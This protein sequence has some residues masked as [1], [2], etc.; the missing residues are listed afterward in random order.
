ML[1]LHRLMAPLH[2]V[3]L[4]IAA[5]MASMLFQQVLKTNPNLFDRLGEYSQSRFGFVPTDLPFAFSIRPS[6]RDIQTVR[7]GAAL[8]AD[9]TITGPLFL[10]LALAEGRVDGDA[11]FFA[12][13]LAVTGD[14]EAILALRNALDDSEI[15]LVKTVGSFSGPLK[16]SVLGLLSSVRRQALRA[17]GVAWS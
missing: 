15:D 16:S 14:M 17:H 12:R 8:A 4:P 13:K 1:A 9:A 3:P 7:R 5:R 2:M 6:V 10:M 11:I